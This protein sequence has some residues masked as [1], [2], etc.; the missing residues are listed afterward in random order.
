MLNKNIYNECI[1]DILPEDCDDRELEF[2]LGGGDST[3]PI[4]FVIVDP[5]LSNQ[6]YF[7]H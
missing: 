3:F 6:T 1:L 4:I 5:T 2:D 7:S